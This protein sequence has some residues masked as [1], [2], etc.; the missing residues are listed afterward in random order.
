MK[1]QFIAILG[2]LGKITGLNKQFDNLDSVTFKKRLGGVS[3]E[4]HQ[5]KVFLKDY[6]IQQKLID[7]VAPKDVSK[8][9]KD[10]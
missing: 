7:K 2:T 5:A 10:Q 1:K 3:Y 8:K 6:L 9:T 4:A